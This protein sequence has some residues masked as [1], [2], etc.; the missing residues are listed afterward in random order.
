[1]ADQGYHKDL[2]FQSFLGKSEGKA[3]YYGQILSIFSGKVISFIQVFLDVLDQR[4]HL[5]S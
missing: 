2:I 3:K 4:A 1:M 5:L